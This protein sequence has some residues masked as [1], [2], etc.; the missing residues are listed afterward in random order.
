LLEIKTV[1]HF[2]LIK[3]LILEISFYRTIQTMYRQMLLLVILSIFLLIFLFFFSSAS[4]PRKFISIYFQQQNNITNRGLYKSELGKNQQELL[5]FD[6]YDYF[7]RTRN[8]ML[9]RFYLPFYYYLF[10]LGFEKCYRFLSSKC[11]WGYSSSF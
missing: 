8:V 11:Y 7:N 5:I 2:F 10:I 9:G 4:S 3:Y 1:S 6:K